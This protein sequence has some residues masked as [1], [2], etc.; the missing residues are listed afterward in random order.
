MDIMYTSIIILYLYNYYMCVAC[1][2]TM[3]ADFK[4]AYIFY[5]GLLVIKS[6]DLRH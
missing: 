1:A 2:Y 3:F 5:N 6:E 4:E